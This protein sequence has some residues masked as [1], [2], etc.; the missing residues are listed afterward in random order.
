[1]ATRIDFVASYDVPQLA[2][3]WT[4][5]ESRSDGTFFLSWAWIGCWL[6]ATGS[7]P[8]L[9]RASDGSQTL[10]LGFLGRNVAR[11]NFLSVLQL[12][13]N[14][15]GVAD[16]DGLMIEHNG[17]LM[18]RDVAAHLPAQFFRELRA[19]QTL[20][21]WDELVL[22]GVSPKWI[23]AAKASGL[24]VE[25]DRI[26]SDYSV[27]LEKVRNSGGSWQAGLS[28]NLRSQFRQSRAFAER[29]GSLSLS[30]ATTAEEAL[31][32]FEGLRTLHT[33]YWTASG[34]P[35][36]FAPDFSVA[37]HRALISQNAES[38]GVEILRL[39]AGNQVLGYLYNFC[40]SG[41]V[42]NYQSGFSYLDDNRHRPGLLAHGFAIEQSLAS[43]MKRYDFLAG[44]S[45]YKKRL[46][47]DAGLLTWC[48]AQ[49]NRPSLVLER[50]ARRVKR[51]LLRRS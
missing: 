24:E 2:Q 13:L 11:R 9:I 15:T 21:S 29:I 22:G 42:S 23:E 19:S 6:A 25:L 20:G 43:G 51:V 32:Y 35:G 34:K 7:R 38:G 14:E 1:M 30:R 31:A 10:G 49:R 41:T 17:L 4:E 37:F 50:L 39:A 8:I 18:A 5:L 16:H 48:R 28:S 46:G 27:D 3:E 40:Y 33:A 44:D 47:E 45:P 36:A 12:C 26:N